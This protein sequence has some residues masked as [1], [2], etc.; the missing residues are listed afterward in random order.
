MEINIDRRCWEK[1][2]KES[3]IKENGRGSRGRIKV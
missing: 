2:I 1:N 3:E